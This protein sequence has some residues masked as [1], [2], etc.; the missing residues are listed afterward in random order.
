MCK[1]HQIKTI[2]VFLCG[3]TNSHHLHSFMR[4]RNN[5]KNYHVISLRPMTFAMN[6]VL[7][8]MVVSPSKLFFILLVE[9]ILLFG[10]WNLPV[11]LN[12]VG[13]RGL[14]SRPKKKKGCSFCSDFKSFCAKWRH[15]QANIANKCR[16]F[17]NKINLLG[18]WLNLF[19]GQMNSHLRQMNP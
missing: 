15:R 7:P 6:H 11:F 1:R 9:C 8:T 14:K 2:C 17:I 3:L 5:V 16:H 4:H 12:D 19:G 10:E 18:E 13:Q